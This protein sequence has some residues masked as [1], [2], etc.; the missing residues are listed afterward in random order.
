[1]FK[2]GGPIS[3]LSVFNK[4]FEKLIHLRLSEFLTTNNDISDTQFAFK[5]NVI[6]L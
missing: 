2:S 4:L 6:L 3:T 5:K 1:M